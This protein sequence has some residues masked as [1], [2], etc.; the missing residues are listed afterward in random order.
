MGDCLSPGC[1]CGGS[2]EQ[3]RPASECV[4]SHP[5][6]PTVS[7]CLVASCAFLRASS[8]VITIWPSAFIETKTGFDDLRFRFMNPIIAKA[9]G[10]GNI[11]KNLFKV[12]LRL[13]GEEEQTSH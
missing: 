9:E 3:N 13:W 11:E 8:L 1:H 2:S 4:R 12:A 10:P 5:G 7:R 6:G